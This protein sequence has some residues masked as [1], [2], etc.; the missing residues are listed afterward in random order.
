MTIAVSRW[1]RALPTWALALGLVALHLVVTFQVRP[2][3][4]W[5]DGIFVLNDAATFPDLT[6][7]LDHHALR[8]RGLIPAGNNSP[9]P[10]CET[11]NCG[12]NEK[13]GPTQQQKSNDYRDERPARPGAHHELLRIPDA[14]FP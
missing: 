13:E 4:R 5:N 14:S 10:G 8:D 1:A 12:A 6:R 3:P 9:G 7:D 11:S 2:H